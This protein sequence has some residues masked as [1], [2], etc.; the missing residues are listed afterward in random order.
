MCIDVNLVFKI[1]IVYILYVLGLNHTIYIKQFLSSPFLLTILYRRDQ[2]ACWDSMIRSLCDKNV[3]LSRKITIIILFKFM[4]KDTIYTAVNIW[5]RFG[6]S[7]FCWQPTYL[8]WNLDLHI[9]MRIYVNLVV[10]DLNTFYLYLHCNFLKF[11]W[12][13]FV[14]IRVNELVIVG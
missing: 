1:K 14:N 9:S 4:F 11:S 3:L 8:M 6:N 10:I 5:S 7:I 13:C 2:I 12:S